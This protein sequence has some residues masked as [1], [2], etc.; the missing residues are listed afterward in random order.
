MAH[1]SSIDIRLPQSSPALSYGRVCFKEIINVKIRLRIR[2]WDLGTD[3]LDV[4]Y[5]TPCP[6]SLAAYLSPNKEKN[7]SVRT[8]VRRLS[9]AK[10]FFLLALV[11]RL[12]IVANRR[13]PHWTQ[14]SVLWPFSQRTDSFRQGKEMQTHERDYLSSKYCASTTKGW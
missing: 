7:K 9:R 13:R 10:K 8:Q 2:K 5:D 14:K 4:R 12:L 6:P 3:A 1:H 11:F